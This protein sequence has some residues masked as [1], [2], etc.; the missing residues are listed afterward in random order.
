M[1]LL[2]HTIDS[3]EHIIRNNPNYGLIATFIISFIES[4]AIIGSIIPGSVTMSIIGSLVGAAILPLLPTLG[5]AFIGSYTG[6]II[7][8]TVGKKCQPKLQSLTWIKNNKKWIDRAEVF[9]EKYGVISIIVGRFFGPMRSMVPMIAGALKMGNIKFLLSAIPSAALWAIVYLIPGILIGM[10]SNELNLF[11]KENIFIFMALIITICI[12]SFYFPR[13]K[14]NCKKHYANFIKKYLSNYPKD[15]IDWLLIAAINIIIF[16]LFALQQGNFDSKYS[17]YF[18]IQ[19]LHTTTLD[20]IISI[21]TLLGD[22]YFFAVTIMLLVIFT[23]KDEYKFIIKST[24]ICIA[25][26]LLLKEFMHVHR[27]PLIDQWN[28]FPSGHSIRISF[29]A[30]YLYLRH[31]NNFSFRKLIWSTIFLV[32]ISRLY[33]GAHWWPDVIAG[34]TFGTACIYLAHSNTTQKQSI[35]KNKRLFSS[36][37]II[38]FIIISFFRSQTGYME[39]FLR[40]PNDIYIS[41]EFWLTNNNLIPAYLNN[42]FNNPV[43]PLNI[44]WQGSEYEIAKYLHE[45]G[46]HTCKW[47]SSWFERLSQ[48]AKNSRLRFLPALP[49]LHNNQAPTIIAI[50]ETNNMLNVISLWETNHKINNKSLLI[51]NIIRYRIYQHEHHRTY[52]KEGYITIDNNIIGQKYNIKL[53]NLVFPPIKY[54][55]SLNAKLAKI[56]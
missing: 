22:K 36:L 20:Y 32:A 34:V 43:E 26:T 31:F 21:I 30:N 24:L 55:H 10:F 38:A 53:Y 48:S 51:G 27:P 15:N 14:F 35:I 33:L 29:I 18:L 3:I 50:K 56:Y 41:K 45:N 16:T 49:K 46:W 13:I 28:S 2:N 47:P 9:I 54:I 8:F 39:F 44:Q 37:L 52:H 5:L 40:K 17:I 19:S 1:I 4:L 11:S 6:D 42:R 25:C 12:L 23:D 7:S